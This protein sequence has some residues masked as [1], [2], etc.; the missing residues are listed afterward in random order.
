MYLNTICNTFRVTESL[1][2]LAQSK[3]ALAEIKQSLNDEAKWVAKAE[4]LQISKLSV[5]QI[6]TVINRIT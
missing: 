3:D 1:Q 6:N 5:K 4:K 2:L